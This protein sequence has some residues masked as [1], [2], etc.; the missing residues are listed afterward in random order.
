[1]IVL[2]PTVREMTFRLVY[3]SP[4][5]F[6]LSYVLASSQKK[7]LSSTWFLICWMLLVGGQY[8][9]LKYQRESDLFRY[10]NGED[11]SVGM[12]EYQNGI[13]AFLKSVW[14]YNSVWLFSGDMF[15]KAKSQYLGRV[16]AKPILKSE[17]EAPANKETAKSE[18]KKEVL[19]RDNLK[20]TLKVEKKNQI[21]E[22]TIKKEKDIQTA[23]RASFADY[24]DEDVVGSKI[25][26]ELFDQ[27]IK[28]LASWRSNRVGP[29]YTKP[30]DRIK[31]K[32]GDLKYFLNLRKDKNFRLNQYSGL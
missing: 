3:N 13:K 21:A 19:K 31:Y 32:I 2:T 23:K 26:A 15:E 4:F 30:N 18:P 8:T 14:Q 12:L 20:E 5:A 1:M 22:Q 17:V 29:I 10:Q 11:V 24:D 27:A 28:T 9:F 25:A 6:G 7:D 16:P